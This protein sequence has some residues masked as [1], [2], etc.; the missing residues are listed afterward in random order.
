MP[1]Y[2]KVEGRGTIE[3]HGVTIQGDG[4]KGLGNAA[5][6]FCA[7]TLK[8]NIEKVKEITKE[9]YEELGKH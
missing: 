1:N 4:K 7:K 6:Q 9:E 2:F 8:E 5:E 3:V